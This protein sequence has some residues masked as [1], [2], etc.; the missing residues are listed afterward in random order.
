[1]DH[2]VE[3]LAKEA[4]KMLKK[5]RREKHGKLIDWSL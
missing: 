5:G 4:G 2:V 1:M 3:A